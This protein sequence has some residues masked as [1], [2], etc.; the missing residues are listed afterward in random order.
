MLL[1]KCADRKI[2]KWV[3]F[4]WEGREQSKKNMHRII[5]KR[6]VLSTGE[7]LLTMLFAGFVMLWNGRKERRQNRW[8]T[9]TE[10]DETTRDSPASASQRFQSK[11]GDFGGRRW[12]GVDGDA[13]LGTNDR[14]G[15]SH[16]IRK[17]RQ[18]FREDDPDAMQESISL[19]NWDNQW[20]GGRTRRGKQRGTKRG[21]KA[22]EYVD[23]SQPSN[24]NGYEHKWVYWQMGSHHAEVHTGQHCYHCAAY[25]QHIV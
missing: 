11:Q 16:L 22:A 5:G 1:Q 20:T 25:Q 7:G 13:S 15:K 10:K 14:V 21:A 12:T 19:S 17:A 4:I 2:G 24:D 6:E 18:A 9:W 8:S 23:E 3:G